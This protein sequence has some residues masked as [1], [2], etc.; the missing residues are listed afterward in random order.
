MA[1]H[2]T[3][4]EFSQLNIYIYIYVCVCVCV[5]VCAR[6]RATV[7]KVTLKQRT[8]LINSETAMNFQ[9]PVKKSVHIL[10]ICLTIYALS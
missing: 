7:N 1:Y 9:T 4:L 10:T 3:M 8:R 5:C 6:T 2:T